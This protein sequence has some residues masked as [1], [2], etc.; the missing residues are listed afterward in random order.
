MGDGISRYLNTDDPQNQ[1][2]S[3]SLVTACDGKRKH[4]SYYVICERT[5]TPLRK[6]AQI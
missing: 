6:Y 4:M 3:I 1:W 5:S 2:H